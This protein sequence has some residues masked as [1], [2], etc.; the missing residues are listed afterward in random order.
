[1]GD[2]IVPVLKIA[3]LALSLAPVAVAAQSA[4]PA[5]QL[6]FMFE[7]EVLLAARVEVGGTAFGQRGYIPI[8]GGTFSGPAIKGKVV[9]GGWDW[10][11]QTS[12]GCSSLHADYFLQTDDGVMFNVVN[13]G[14][15]CLE[16][17]QPFTPAFTQPRFEAP[18][19]RYGWLNHGAWISRLEGGKDPTHPSVVIRF[20]RAR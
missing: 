12:A 14:Q 7:A 10:Q 3:A 9:P 13:H 19:G 1:M 18:M 15:F 6:E 17:G 16:K 8:I 5:P 4:P 20:Y 11:L 2:S